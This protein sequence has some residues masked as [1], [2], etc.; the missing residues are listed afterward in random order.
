MTNTVQIGAIG[1]QADIVLISIRGF[2]DTVAA[3]HLQ[4]RVNALIEEGK[5]KYIINLVELEHVSSAGIGVFSDMAIRLPKYHGKLIFTNVP[6]QVWH[7]FKI[8]RLAE[9]F[10]IRESVQAAVDELESAE[11]HISGT[12]PDVS[13]TPG[14]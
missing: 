2:M 13:T 8:T 7:L 9:I 12:A 5:F 10:P 14:A 4:E 11:E 6:E 3:Y 1:A